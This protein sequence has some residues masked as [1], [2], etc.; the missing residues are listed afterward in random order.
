[1]SFLLLEAYLTVQT[2]LHSLKL[3]AELQTVCKDNP[4]P[5]LLRMDLASG[6]G[7]GKSTEKR[8]AEASDKASLTFKLE[9]LSSVLSLCLQW[10]FVAASQ[11]LEWVGQE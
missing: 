8:I 11:G 10:A 2:A 7:A 1:M 5:L 6:H 4:N 9:V 3:A